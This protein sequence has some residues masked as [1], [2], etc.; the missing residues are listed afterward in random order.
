MKNKE[1]GFT[2]IEMLVV[3]AIVAILPTV[4]IA[5]FPR[6]RQQFALSRA[7]YAFAQDVRSTEGRSLS[8]NLYKDAEGNYQSVAGYGVYLDMSQYGNKKYIIYADASPG[9]Q[10]YD[11]L[12]YIVSTIDLGVNEPGIMVKEL[13]N[14]VGNNA[15]INFN[16]PDPTTTI[17]Q[18]DQ[19]ETGI[20]V[21]FAVES[22]PLQT[23]T[24]SVNSSG[25][26]EVK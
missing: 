25:L 6:I 13:D 5:N 18:L 16:P 10:Q 2:I 22:D 23:K 20:D 3:I 17:T 8:S 15:S 12:D 26:V 14:V 4:V 9:N 11:D 1:R 19:G 7:A 21:V 24:V